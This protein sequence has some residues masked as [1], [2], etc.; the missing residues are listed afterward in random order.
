MR[1]RY[2]LTVAVLGAVVVLPAVASSGTETTPSIEAVN[3]GGLYGEHH[4]WLPAQATIAPGGAVLLSNRSEVAHG[5]EWRGALRPTCEEGAGKVP[6]GTTPAASA[7]KWSGTCKFTQAGTYTFYCT[8]HGPEMTGT[9]TVVASG[10]PSAS[11]G[12][13]SAGE[14]EASLDGTVD[15]DGE[16]TK[17]L[18]EWGPDTKYGQTTAELPLSGEDHT[19]HAVSAKLTG[20][21]PA[22]TYHYRLVAKNASG[23][24]P[25]VDQ[26][27]TTEAPPGA[28]LVSTDPAGELGEAEA[29]LNGTV[30]PDGQATEYLFEWGTSATAY[31]QTTAKLLVAGK[32]HTGHLVS[33]KLTGL[34]ADTEYH[35]RVLATNASE[36]TPVLG[37]DMVFK[38]APTPEPTPQPTP[39]PTPPT[40][41]SLPPAPTPITP[42]AEPVSG[43]PLVGGPALRS[44]QRGASVGG[45]VEVSAAGAGGRLEVDLLAKGASLAGAKR[46]A[47]IRVGHLV[48]G[49]LSAGR[50]SFVVKLDAQ[51]R[52]ALKRL[53]HL[54]LT[55]RITLT[56]AHGRAAV[57]TRAVVLRQ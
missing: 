38:T 24:V 14:T 6:V 33:A 42:S 36:M 43:S 46:S 12:G 17:Y 44:T 55:V 16:A 9:I 19:G 45:A 18:F 10:P 21:A 27:F 2:V 3:A 29:T 23:T 34:A 47:A 22:T 53:R 5:V 32:D 37:T 7:T 11:T 51:A 56:P 49:A 50:V 41:L 8:V 26:Q 35:F 13:A 28:P 57:V 30:N 39:T 25:G 54:A 15:P 4:Y 31:G 1:R 20:L 52:R 40:P 48:R